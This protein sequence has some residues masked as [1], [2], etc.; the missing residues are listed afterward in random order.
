[1]RFCFNILL[2]VHFSAKLKHYSNSYKRQGRKK[3]VQLKILCR[4]N[5]VLFV[6][7]KTVMLC[8]REMFENSRE[9]VTSLFPDDVEPVPWLFHS[10]LVFKRL[11]SYLQRLKTI[12]VS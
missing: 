4:S 8:F 9:V 6:F 10:R 11:N 2:N 3:S 5:Y 1:M 12:H 7:I